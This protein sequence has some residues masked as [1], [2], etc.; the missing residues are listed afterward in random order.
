M[1]KFPFS[2]L[3]SLLT[4]Y[5]SSNNPLEWY[6]NRKFWKGFIGLLTALVVVVQGIYLPVTVVHGEDLTLE[7]P[8]VILME[9]STGQ[10][11][12]EKNADEQRH[13]A[14]VTKVMTLLLAFEQIDAGKMAMTDIVT[15][16]AHAA[17]MGGSQCF[18]EA[19][20]TQTVEDM[21]KCI[22][23]ASGNDAA[24]AMGEHIAGSE[25]AFVN[26]MNEKAAELG[27]V[28][29][30]FVNAC[31]LDA[32]GHLTTARDIALMSRELTTKHPEVFQYSTIWMDTIT[33]VTARGASDFG[34]SNTNK[35]LKT[36]PYCTGLKTGYTSGAGFSISATAS[37][38]GIDL[39]AVVMGASTKD[40]RNS[41]V[42]RLFDYGFAN[43]RMYQDES[44]LG[45]G[46]TVPVKK[47][48]EESVFCVPEQN[49]FYY[50]LTRDQ[51]PE[52]MNKELNYSELSAPVQKGDVI[53]EAVY[54]YDGQRIG[55]V[56][57]LAAEDV[58]AISYGFCFRK[59]LYRLFCIKPAVV[60][61]EEPEGEPPS[62]EEMMQNPSAEDTSMEDTAKTGELPVETLA[63]EEPGT[64]PTEAEATTEPAGTAPEQV[65]EE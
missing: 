34:L 64:E 40:I 2:V 14:S 4:E 53:G 27:M 31:G 15:V 29:S 17:S 41:E 61:E 22:I 28:N 10:V 26:L 63:P 20:E 9:P 1:T 56:P 6:M 37:K 43:C 8:S 55:A 16:S 23:I 46:V 25:E 42:C 19:G 35:L 48:T 59:L 30:H 49:H 65:T 50:M 62:A 24:V 12:Y 52:Q 33:H 11:L 13:P 44:V 38:D 54:Y 36:Y 5:S 32:E 47:G 21:I 39:I 3:I 57:I 7:S 51:I 60:Q 18:F 58:E 45:N